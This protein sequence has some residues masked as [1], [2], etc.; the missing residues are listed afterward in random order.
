[1]V[2]MIGDVDTNSLTV[3][4]SK[5]HQYLQLGM[6]KN[7]NTDPLDDTPAVPPHR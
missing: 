5:D 3:R 2:Q 1:M 7:P 6:N 4:K